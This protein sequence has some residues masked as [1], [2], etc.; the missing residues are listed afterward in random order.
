[1]LH[2]Q[3]DELR[4]IC[5][6]HL[7]GPRSERA[8]NGRGHTSQQNLTPR[9]IEEKTEFGIRVEVEVRALMS[10]MS[11]MDNGYP[12]YPWTIHGHPMNEREKKKWDN[13]KS[14]KQSIHPSI[15]LSVL[16]NPPAKALAIS[17]AARSGVPSLLVGVVLP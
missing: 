10:M 1:M 4:D 15:N 5:P 17:G 7:P 16:A 14:I 3:L 8:G 9:A 11:S 12:G 13:E 6:V 2:S